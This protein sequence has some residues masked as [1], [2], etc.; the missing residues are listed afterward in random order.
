MTWL[1]FGD[2]EA[3]FGI[4]TSSG[5]PRT[6][7]S[8]LA[9]REKTSST[10]DQIVTLHRVLLRK[11]NS[12]THDLYIENCSE[13]CLSVEIWKTTINHIQEALL[14]VS[15]KSNDCRMYLETEYPR[16]YQQMLELWDRCSKDRESQL[17]FNYSPKNS[18]NTKNL[19]TSYTGNT[20]AH[21]D[22]DQDDF[23]LDY[24]NKKLYNGMDEVKT[25]FTNFETAYLGRSLSRMFDAVENIFAAA[26]DYDGSKPRYGQTVYNSHSS[27]WN[28]SENE[29][30]KLVNI[31]LEEL[32]V[33]AVDLKLAVSVSKNIVKTIKKISITAENSLSING[34]EA[35][36]VVNPPTAE[37]MENCCII[38]TIWRLYWKFD[39][40][41]NDLKRGNFH[42]MAAKPASN[43]ASTGAPLNEVSE[44]LTILANSAESWLPAVSSSLEEMMELVNIAITPLLSE[45][46][47]NIEQ[48]ILTMHDDSTDVSS[49]VCYWSKELR[50]FV[51]RVVR[52]HFTTLVCKQAIMERLRG[53]SRRAVV[54]ATSNVFLVKYANSDSKVQ[55]SELRNNLVKGLNELEQAL[56]PLI[57]SPG[58]LITVSDC[59]KL[60]KE[61]KPLLM[62]SPENIL[63][64]ILNLEEKLEQDRPNSRLSNKSSDEGIE[65]DADN[66]SKSAIYWHNYMLAIWQR[67][68]NDLFA[69][70]PIGPNGY[71]A[72]TNR[73]SN[74]HKNNIIDC[75]HKFI[76]SEKRTESEILLL[77]RYGLENY[78]SNFKGDSF[79]DM[80]DLLCQGVK[81]FAEVIQKQNS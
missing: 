21:V 6:V 16:L 64:N 41:F 12:V 40:Q 62:S 38:N 75:Y 51:S 66:M 24:Q 48:I 47:K 10:I 77:H 26:A 25:L 2:G 23:D 30:E 81:K 73:L 79:D 33:S 13:K 31:M 42:N 28:I 67:A 56:A 43:S 1:R 61:T 59:G 29:L 80:Y 22:E 8:S 69:Y 15:K 55:Q 76:L 9:L 20:A 70:S 34:K 49:D 17:A 78:E 68:E 65:P 39:L 52:E 72:K 19:A 4:E 11:R 18:K 27:K 45:I 53:L 74:S 36:Q 7:F 46:A 63:K 58:G 14:L 54:Q 44:A 37:Q 60:L 50:D 5:F 71:L 32:E 57:T 3:V 35:V